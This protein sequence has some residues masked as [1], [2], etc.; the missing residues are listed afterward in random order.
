MHEAQSSVV[1]WFIVSFSL[2][3]EA[4]SM[5][6]ALEDACRIN[7]LT[8]L[9]HPNIALVFNHSEEMFIATHTPPL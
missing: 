5:L 9:K 8:V 2:C 7:S 4:E 1:L 6:V 3:H